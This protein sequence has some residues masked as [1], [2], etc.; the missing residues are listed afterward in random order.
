MDSRHAVHGRKG[1]LRPPERPCP[2]RELHAGICKSERESIGPYRKPVDECQLIDRGQTS[3]AM[4]SPDLGRQP[5]YHHA[6]DIEFVQFDER[7]QPIRAEGVRHL[8]RAGRVRPDI[9]RVGR[10][11]IDGSIA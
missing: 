10:Q 9:L 6:G 8:G 2:P 11:N 5:A 1:G 4:G 3:P 7:R